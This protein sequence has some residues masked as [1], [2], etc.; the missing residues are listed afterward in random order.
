MYKSDDIADLIR[1]Q[2]MANLKRNEDSYV[3]TWLKSSQKFSILRDFI[4]GYS[5]NLNEK[6]ETSQSRYDYKLLLYKKSLCID[7]N[8]FRRRTCFPIT[9]FQRINAIL[10]WSE[11]FCSF[12]YNLST[13]LLS[14]HKLVYL[15]YK[16]I[17]VLEINIH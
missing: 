14:L 9:S 2:L 15:K 12:I 10:F 16:W 13:G 17:H 4:L 8:S 11:S 1:R 7:S 5:C 3:K 6:D